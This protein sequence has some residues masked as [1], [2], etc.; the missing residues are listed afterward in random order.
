MDSLG[1]VAFGA[2]CAAIGSLVTGYLL[3]AAEHRREMRDAGPL[4]VERKRHLDR[5]EAVRS[6]S[7]MLAELRHCV[8]HVRGDRDNRFVDGYTSKGERL[9]LEIRESARAEI[10]GLGPEMVAA[11]TAVTD[12][13]HEI[14]SATLAARAARDLGDVFADEQLLSQAHDWKHELGNVLTL[15]GRFERAQ[16]A[17]WR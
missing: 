6:L 8:D 7:G 17:G 13:A 10:L 1:T 2:A 9:R 16:E 4:E 11:I 3:K 14:L 5:Y 12:H 15:L